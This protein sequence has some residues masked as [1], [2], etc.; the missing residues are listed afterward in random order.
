MTVKQL[1]RKLNKLPDDVEVIVFNSEMYV[2]GL[3]A[4]SDI[5][6]YEKDN[7]VEIETNFDKKVD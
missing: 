2:Q 1:R 7:A 6:Y 5:I 3:Y 4:T